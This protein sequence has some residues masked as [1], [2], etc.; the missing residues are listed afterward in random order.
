MLGTSQFNIYASILVF[1]NPS[2]FNQITET[3]L[4]SCVSYGLRVNILLCSTRLQLIHIYFR[5]FVIF[6]SPLELTHGNDNYLYVNRK[7]ITASE[8]SSQGQNSTKCCCRS[9][10]KF[11]VSF[12][13]LYFLIVQHVHHGPEILAL[14]E[15]ITSTDTFMTR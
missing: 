8:K 9:L 5:L 12:Q 11:V 13:S 15:T 3:N 14:T 10:P 4:T 7:K 6:A 2:Q 1:Y